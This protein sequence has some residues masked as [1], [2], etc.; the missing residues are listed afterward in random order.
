[1]AGWCVLLIGSY[2]VLEKPLY[3]PP[4]KKNI[5][6]PESKRV[7]R[8]L[9]RALMTASALRVQDLSKPFELFCVKG[10]ACH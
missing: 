6:T 4:P 5:W 10:C 3:D 7:F 8:A 1:M 2:G 9:K